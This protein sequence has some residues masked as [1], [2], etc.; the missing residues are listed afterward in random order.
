MHIHTHKNICYIYMLI[1]I[2]Y[3]SYKIFIYNLK[4]NVSLCPISPD[5]ISIKNLSYNLLN[6]SHCI[7]YIITFH[8]IIMKT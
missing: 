6:F 3:H 2:M 8:F 5:I 7:G 1:K 4:M